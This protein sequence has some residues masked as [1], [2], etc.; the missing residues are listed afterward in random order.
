MSGDQDQKTSDFPAIGASGAI[1][2][3]PNGFF[4][5]KLAQPTASSP[6]PAPAVVG[7]RNLPD[8]G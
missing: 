6:A 3:L 8:R 2:I 7:D 4:A 1:G 5:Q